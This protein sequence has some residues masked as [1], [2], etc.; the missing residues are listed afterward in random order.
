MARKVPVEEALQILEQAQKAGLVTQTNSAQNPGGICNCCGD[1]CQALIP[2]NRIPKP[3]DVVFSNY[4][5]RVET[6]LCMACGTCLERCQMSA[7]DKDAEDLAL[8]NLDRCIGCGLCVSSCPTEAMRLMLKPEGMR[9]IPP[10]T[11]AEQFALLA[12]KR[13][14]LVYSK[15]SIAL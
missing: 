13:G 9:K 6:I 11:I 7:I 1:C 15:V 2:L 8:I 4:F 12:K 3:A 10:V 14:G 5:A